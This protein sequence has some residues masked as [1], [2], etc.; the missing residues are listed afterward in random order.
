MWAWC[1]SRSTVAVA[2]VLGMISSNPEGVQ[3]AADGERAPFVGGVDQA[4]E[5][6]G[7]VGT[8]GQQADVVQLCGYPHRS[9]YVEPATMPMSYG[10]GLSFA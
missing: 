5:A 3:I 2:R 7:C 4:V 10:T 1:M 6:L 8:D 9:T